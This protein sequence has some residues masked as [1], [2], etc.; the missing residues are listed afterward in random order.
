MALSGQFIP[1]TA[2]LQNL[3]PAAPFSIVT[4]PT[5]RTIE[6]A[7]TNSFGFGG[8]NASLILRRLA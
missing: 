8:A 2:S 4:A 6:F 1:P 3:D 5:K 7:L